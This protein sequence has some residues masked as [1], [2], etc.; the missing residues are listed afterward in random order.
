MPL[1]MKDSLSPDLEKPER[2]RGQRSR[3]RH[4]SWSKNYRHPES[5]SPT[6]PEVGTQ[7]AIQEET[8]CEETDGTSSL[9]GLQLGKPIALGS[10]QFGILDASMVK[11]CAMSRMEY[12]LYLVLRLL[13]IS[14]FLNIYPGSTVSA[15]LAS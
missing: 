12:V 13:V 10:S 7:G 5:E 9:E 14:G 1:K 15:H 8:S 6:R 4:Q 11:R 3:A 2:W